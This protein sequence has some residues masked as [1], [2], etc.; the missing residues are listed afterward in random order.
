MNNINDRDQEEDQRQREINAATGINVNP[1]FH[2]DHADFPDVDD[3]IEGFSDGDSGYTLSGQDYYNNRQGFNQRHDPVHDEPEMTRFENS[4][5]GND[6]SNS[7]LYAL[8]FDFN[9]QHGTPS[10][11][12]EGRTI[13]YYIEERDDSTSIV[14]TYSDENYNTLL[15]SHVYTNQNELI[16]FLRYII[17]TN[18]TLLG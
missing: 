11:T 14:Y 18:Y 9:D 5:S 1:D 10:Y 3:T 12:Y 15:D 4:D 8:E 16:L 2:D 6:P 13:Y 17:V 7:S